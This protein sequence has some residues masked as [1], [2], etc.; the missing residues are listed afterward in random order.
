MS[1]QRNVT[2]VDGDAVTCPE[3]REVDD[4]ELYVD[5]DPSS[6]SSSSFA[7]LRTPRPAESGSR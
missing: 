3:D 5:D 6:S 7:T 1:D 2:W 4:L